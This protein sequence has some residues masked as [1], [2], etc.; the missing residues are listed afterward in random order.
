MQKPLP[1]IDPGTA[2][3]WRGLNE[4]RL[5]LRSCRACGQPHF[6]PRE[7]CP[8]CYA[9]DLDWVEASGRAEIYSYTV[10]HRPAGPAFADDAPYVVAIVTLAEGPRMM[11]WIVNDP[12]EVAIGKAVRLTLRKVADE[13][14]LPMFEL[15]D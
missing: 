4:G 7:I 6:Y 10:A 12:A 8:H 15:C 1:T 13:V 9:D 3:Y 11:T 14:T 5:L 2:P